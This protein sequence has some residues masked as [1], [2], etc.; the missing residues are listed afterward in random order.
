[1]TLSVQAFS[2]QPSSFVIRH[3]SFIIRFPIIHPVFRRLAR[4]EKSLQ[5][6]ALRC[7]GMQ[8]DAPGCTANFSKKFLTGFDR[9]LLGC[10]DGKWKG[11]EEIHNM[12]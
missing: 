2:L 11:D 12:D 5:R 9:G 10:T 8:R 3:S 6:V 4:S 7:T 1:M